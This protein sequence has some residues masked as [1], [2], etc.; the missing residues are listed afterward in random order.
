MFVKLTRSGSRSYVQLVESYRDESGKPRQRTI[1]TVGRLDETGGAVQSLLSGL[2]RATGQPAAST[3]TMAPAAP[4]TPSIRFDSS[5]AYGDVFALD[6]L[7]HEL[8]FDEIAT[9]LRSARLSFDA[10]ALVGVDLFS[11][12][13]VPVWIRALAW[14]HHCRLLILLAFQASS[15]SRIVSVPNDGYKQCTA[16]TP[17]T[18]V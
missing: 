10:E 1:A 2:L 13:K 8:G 5:L 14:G 12:S 17:R 4:G 18:W 3:G 9:L 7:W 16:G 15:L 6:R 11:M